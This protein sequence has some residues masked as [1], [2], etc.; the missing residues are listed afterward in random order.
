VTSPLVYDI[1]EVRWTYCGVPSA[2]LGYISISEGA[3]IK[4]VKF[5]GECV[6]GKILGIQERTKFVIVGIQGVFKKRP[7]F[8]YKDFI[9]HFTAF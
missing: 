2:V 9:T 4:V 6:T 7:N 1:C 8:C 5:A 3:H